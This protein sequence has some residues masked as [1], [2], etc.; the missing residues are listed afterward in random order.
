M[1][2]DQGFFFLETTRGLQNTLMGGLGNINPICIPHANHSKGRV[3][4]GLRI[5]T[6]SPSFEP[7]MA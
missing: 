3:V 1:A 5:E 7:L 2:I 6:R 4:S